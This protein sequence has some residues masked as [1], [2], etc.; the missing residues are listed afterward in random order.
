MVFSGFVDHANVGMI[1]SG[2]GTRFPLQTFQATDGSGKIGGKKLQRH[3]ARQH[4]VFSP[5]DHAHAASPQH[6]YDAE[7]PAH[8]VAPRQ[9]RRSRKLLGG[10]MLK[11]IRGLRIAAEQPSHFSHDAGTLVSLGEEGVAGGWGPVK[12][13]LEQNL[14]SL[15]PF[16]SHWYNSL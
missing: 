1:Q 12:G 10:R 15:P 9:E 11:E 4:H 6:A 16:G 8:Q 5:V 13:L 14:H 3:R 7:L 2:G